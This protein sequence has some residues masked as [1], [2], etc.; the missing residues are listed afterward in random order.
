MD[1][2]FSVKKAYAAYYA[3][4]KIGFLLIIIFYPAVLPAQTVFKLTDT[5]YISQSLILYKSPVHSFRYVD[6]TSGRYQYISLEINDSTGT[7]AL[8]IRGDTAWLIKGLM[9]QMIKT[10]EL[11]GK[12]QSVTG[13]INLDRIPNLVTDTGWINRYRANLSEYRKAYDQIYKR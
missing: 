1:Y 6:N 13:M 2:L 12:L 5:G 11:Y 9:N 3:I 7:S 10:S 8:S 4:V